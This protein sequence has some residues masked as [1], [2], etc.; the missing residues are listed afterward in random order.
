MIWM[1]QIIYHADEVLTTPL[2]EYPENQ[3]AAM[4]KALR[5]FGVNGAQLR[6]FGIDPKPRLI[7]VAGDQL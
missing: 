3:A 2:H 4:E 5:E 7:R 1:L 6:L